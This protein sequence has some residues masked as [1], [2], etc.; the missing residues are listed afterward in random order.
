MLRKPAHGQD[1]VVRLHDHITDL[2][3]VGEDG[4]GI[5]DLFGKVIRQLL[6]QQRAQPRACPSGN[7]VA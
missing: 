4:K 6:Q 1:R 2:F 5:E 7:R 3:R